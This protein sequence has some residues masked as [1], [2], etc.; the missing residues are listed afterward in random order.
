MI[1]LL[2][3]FSFMIS[4][5]KFS[6]ASGTFTPDW[7]KISGKKLP[8]VTFTDANGSVVRISEY[9]NKILIL[10]PMFTHCQSTCTFISSRLSAAINGLSVEE[11][12][13]FEIV[14]F[15]FDPNE[16][17]ESLSKFEK[18]FQMDQSLWK[19]VRTDAASVQKLL[20]ALDFRTL[21]LA[22]SNYEHPNLI[23]IV[24]KDGI[25][26]DYIYGSDLTSDRLNG[27]LRSAEK[28][29]SKLPGLKS[30]LYIL[31]VIGLLISSF[32][33]ATHLTKARRLTS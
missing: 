10:H 32:F 25:L 5:P 17:S 2:L 18:M 4:S 24:S 16:T 8:D 31:A 6:N 14:S 33:V 23:F 21:Q 1:F 13:N 12:N 11:R 7:E 22:E 3:I 9:K 28:G 30:Y 26:Q 20:A 19:V 15:S 27:L 29:Y